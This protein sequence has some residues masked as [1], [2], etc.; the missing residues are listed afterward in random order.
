MRDDF[1]ML[2]VD[3]LCRLV[4]AAVCLFV[5]ARPAGAQ[6]SAGHTFAY[7]EEAIRAT[8]ACPKLKL[9]RI[10]LAEIAAAANL[11][12]SRMLKALDENAQDVIQPPPPDP[13][14]PEPAQPPKAGAVNPL[15]RAALAQYGPTGTRFVGLIHE[16]TA[17]Q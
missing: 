15:C 4:C 17:G 6:E 13:A 1:Q 10:R 8:E 7:L 5:I 16:E 14:M 11:T 12:Q 3:G 2:S 9:D